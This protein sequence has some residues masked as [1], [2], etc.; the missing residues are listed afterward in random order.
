MPQANEP[1]LLDYLAGKTM[2]SVLTVCMLYYSGK[3]AEAQYLDA[4]A[5]LRANYRHVRRS[6]QLSAAKKLAVLAY[7]ISPK[8]VRGIFHVLPD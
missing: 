8:L 6:S 5:F 4:V 2:V 1:E 3:V 7:L